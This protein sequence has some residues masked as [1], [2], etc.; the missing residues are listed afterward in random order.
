GAEQR[1]FAV[2]ALMA[3][4][5]DLLGKALDQPVVDLDGLDA[6]H[7]GM[8][9]VLHPDLAGAVDEDLGNG[10]TPEP[11]AERLQVG[12]EIGAAARCDGRRLHARQLVNLR[13]HSRGAREKSRS[14]AVNTR[15]GSPC[16]T[17]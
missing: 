5:S 3:D 6:L 17:R 4:T 12:I 13:A 16:R 10:V 11:F 8:G 2:D 9:G 15:I 1:V 14:R 7:S